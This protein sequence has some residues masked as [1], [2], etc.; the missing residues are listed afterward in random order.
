MKTGRCAHALRAWMSSKNFTSIRPWVWHHV[1]ANVTVDLASPPT[2]V[3]VGPLIGL[4]SHNCRQGRRSWVFQKRLESG[5]RELRF[6]PVL[7]QDSFRRILL[8]DTHAWLL[9]AAPAATV[10]L[11]ATFSPATWGSV[12]SAV[13][14]AL[15]PWGCGSVG[16]W[17]HVCWDCPLRLSNAPWRLWFGS[18]LLPARISSGRLRNLAALGFHPLSEPWSQDVA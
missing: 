6:L 3:N 18:G 11:G 7:P 10:A 17:F 16:Y 5:R 2:S 8:D 1:G 13:K 15:C 14:S 9:S 12:P 4:A